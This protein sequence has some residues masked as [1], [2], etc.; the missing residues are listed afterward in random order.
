LLDGVEALISKSLLQQMEGHDEEARFWMLETIHEYAKEKLWE[1]GEEEEL[2]RRHA[3]YF[4]ELVEQAAPHLKQKDQA[5]W[6]EQLED[7]HDNI[8]AAFHWAREYG[9]RGDSEAAEIGLRLAIGLERFWQV[10]VHLREGLE[11]T[12]GALAIGQPGGATRAR[13]LRVAATLADACG[14]YAAA[15][16]MLEE[17]MQ[18]W[19]ELGDKRSLIDTLHALGNVLYAQGDYV[20][21]R[22][23]YEE[24]LDIEQEL[25]DRKTSVH[26]L[27]LVFYEQGDFSSAASLLEEDLAIERDIG[28]TRRVALALANLGLV[29][30]EQGDYALALSRDLESLA[31]RQQ[32]GAKLG[33]V[34]S[35]EGLAMVYRGLSRPEK[36]ARLWGAAQV[37]R[38]SVGAPVPPNERTRYRRE[39]DMVRAQLGEYGFQR[40]YAEG[41]S[42]TGEQ[43]V[44]YVFEEAV[45]KTA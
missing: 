34:F 40:A 23:F 10:R 27:G 9:E 15:Y 35:L 30:F 2:R 17:S 41:H 4:I 24:S 36:A 25:G 16:S 43:A 18:I 3:R 38:E 7:E 37:M 32:I 44:A 29:A 20:K 12:I 21:A 13:A 39:M 8:R 11:Q 33:I 19:Q 26:N 45:E 14:N 42:M 22:S 6:L 5:R 1:S 28:D 31:I